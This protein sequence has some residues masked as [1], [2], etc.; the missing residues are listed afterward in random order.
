[1]INQIYDANRLRKI[2]LIDYLHY[3][4]GSV[5]LFD[6][7]KSYGY[8]ALISQ[9]LGNDIRISDRM[10]LHSDIDTSDTARYNDT[11]RLLA[12]LATGIKIEKMKSNFKRSWL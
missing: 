11:K 1:M 12:L 3:G 8:I 4:E 5:E 7:G 10:F 9:R 6:K 2:L